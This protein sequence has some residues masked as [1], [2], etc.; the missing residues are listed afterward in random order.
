MDNPSI[1]SPWDSPSKMHTAVKSDG[2]RRRREER[3]N[4]KSP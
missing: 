3:R 4:V 1:D 2:K